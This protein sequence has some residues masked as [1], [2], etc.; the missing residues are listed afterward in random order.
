MHP[1]ALFYKPTGPDCEASHRRVVVRIRSGKPQHVGGNTYDA[2]G[3]EQLLMPE[4]AVYVD[5]KLGGYWLVPEK[6]LA[7]V[8]P[9]NEH[10]L[11][12]PK[13]G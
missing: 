3:K 11:V 7:E 13:E 5:A 12:L 9:G 1:A 8:T 6:A 4:G 10:T 2:D